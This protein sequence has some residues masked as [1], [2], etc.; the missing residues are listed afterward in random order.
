MKKQ[1]IAALAAVGALALTACAG[2]GGTAGGGDG[3]PVVDG[4]LRLAL[5]EDPGNLFRPLNSS[6]T[7]S[8]V[9]PWA[10]ES[11]VYF[12]ENGEA[13]GWLAKSWEETPTSLKFEIRDDAVCS[14]G[15][16]LT[17]ETVANN[18]KWILDPA[19]GSSFV[20]LVIPADA[21]IENDATTVTLTTTTPNSFLLT[22]VGTHPIYCQA[23]LDDPA[24]VSSAT[25]G[26]GMF[27]LTEAVPGDHYTLERRDDY[28]WGPEGAPVG[29]TPGVP[30][31]VVISIVENDSTR[32]NLLLS[33]DLN[34]ASVPGP[35]GER[36]AAQLK[37]ISEIS[38][39]SGGF[40]YSQAEGMPTADKN[41]RI[42]LTKALDLDAL[43]KVQTSDKGERAQRLAVTPP[44]IC[45][46]DAATPNLPSLDVAE[47]EKMLDD[48]GWV[49]GADGIRAK[50]G[51]PLELDFAWQT[52]WTE[53]AATAEMIGQ[54]WAEIGVKVKQDGSDYGAFSEKVFAEGA[55]SVF[56]V[57]W[58]APNY[59]VPN[60]LASF[61]SGAVPPEGNNIGAISNP[62]FDKLV[63]ESA[64]FSGAE[65]CPSWEAAES[66]MYASA[67][68]VPFAMRSD[69][70]YGQGVKA[71]IQP[72]GLDTFV[73][74]IIL[75]N[76]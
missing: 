33:G 13:Q 18:Y 66:E 9:Y 45:Q 30:K 71:V 65:A 64:A 55:S 23:A 68:Y 7:L 76:E 49:K 6:A 59:P 43:M 61:F 54:Q 26:T 20:G 24:S 40:V 46:Y 12:D 51:Q 1:S 32:A 5:N 10:Y 70:A 60:V 63:A 8:Y 21:V 38:M 39:L 74:G 3:E 44:Q 27:Q 11:P 48:A 53:N 69:A 57:M 42:A 72:T 41:V 29:D 28:T 17:A 19:N 62:E 56:D 35:D 36:V 31:D 4:T 67:D 50:D 2:G 52:R 25:N 16:P 37:P 15:T 73:T 58:I 14:D 34:I 22:A 47:A 75:V